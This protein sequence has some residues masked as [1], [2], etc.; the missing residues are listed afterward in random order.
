MSPSTLLFM[1]K[2]PA[3]VRAAMQE[4]L[5]AHALD[6]RLG[7]GLFPCEHW[8]QSLSNLFDDTPDL[9]ARLLNV[10]EQV[11]GTAFSM[12]FNRVAGNA[13]QAGRIHW[14]FLA[15]GVPDGFA[16]LLAAI[17]TGL[18]AQGLSVG[19]SHT[20]H[21][22]ISYRAPEPLAPTRIALI[23]W[24]V[25]QFQLVERGGDPFGYREIASWSLRPAEAAAGFQFGLL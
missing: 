7:A 5:A 9:R 24:P 6:R 12:T 19:N 14:S 2:P 8:H 4:A 23:P 13:G 17:R 11:S 16:T 20:P 21:V 15:R 10:G 3:A 18:A 22:T 25:E 1:A